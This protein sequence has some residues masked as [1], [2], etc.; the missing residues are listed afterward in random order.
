MKKM[1]SLILIVVMTLSC[2]GGM[3]ESLEEPVSFEAKISLNTDVLKKAV[4][5]DSE[6]PADTVKALT[7]IRDILDVLTLKGVADKDSL[8]LGLF[9][10]EDEVITLGV[11]GAEEGI[12]VVSSFI[13]GLALNISKEQITAVTAQNTSGP[14]IQALIAAVQNLDE[15]QLRKDVEE[16]NEKLGKAF[17]EKKGETEAGEFTVD[18]MTFTGKTPVNVTYTEMM[19]LVVVNVKD[20]LAKESLQPIIKALGQNVDINAELDKALEK[21]KTQAEEEKPEMQITLY[22]DA[23]Q[24]EYATIDLVSTTP[25]TDVKPAQEQKVYVGFGKVDG[26]NRS[27][28]TMT[29]NRMNMEIFVTGKDDGSI[30]EKITVNS[31]D[32]TAVAIAS[33]DAAGN[34][35]MEETVTSKDV[36]AKIVAKGEAAEGDRKNFAL[37]V[38]F[39]DEAEA[40]LSINGTAGKG[41]EKFCTFEGDGI[42]VIPVE[43][44]GDSSDTS[45]YTQL[46]TGVQTGIMGALGTLMKNLPSESSTWLMQ[47]LMPTSR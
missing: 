43:K 26:L 45:A 41:G 8:E 28:I 33:R 5:G 9:A 18:E 39:G 22:T 1:L 42:T 20:L 37:D 25:A 13:K 36:K 23:D 6:I 32:A 44:L 14:D 16:I 4:A 15:E 11:K 17:E 29:D 21:I 12:T 7:A 35:T 30:D 2:I 10:G 19:E 40:L 27:R 3:A 47:Q 34:F 46:M 24:C 31:D 38:F